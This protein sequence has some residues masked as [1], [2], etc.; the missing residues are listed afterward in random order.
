[1]KKE[2]AFSKM[3]ELKNLYTGKRQA[4]GINLSPEVESLVLRQQLVALK[5][6]HPLSAVKIPRGARRPA[7]RAS[8]SRRG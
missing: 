1:M 8:S 4:V 7:R 6:R 3:K 5:G 2:Y